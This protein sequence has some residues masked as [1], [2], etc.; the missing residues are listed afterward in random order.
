MRHGAVLRISE[1]RVRAERDIFG[2]SMPC[3]G[4]LSMLPPLGTVGST[5]STLPLLSALPLK[6]ADV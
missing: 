5:I 1:R 3:D 4:K 2:T 6:F